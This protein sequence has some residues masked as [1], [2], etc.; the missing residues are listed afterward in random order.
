MRRRPSAGGAGAGFGAGGGAGFITGVGADLTTGVVANVGRCQTDMI[1]TLQFS[2]HDLE[3]VGIRE[4]IVG[5][6]RNPFRIVLPEP[7]PQT[8]IAAG[9]KAQVGTS[10]DEL[11]ITNERRKRG[12]GF[13]SGTVV[14]D[15]YRLERRQ[16][17][18]GLDLAADRIVAITDNDN[19]IND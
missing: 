8:D 5:G 12:L 18:E 4:R 3:R 10:H 14:D 19:D 17:P 13:R 15:E 2:E 16:V 7:P 1:A 9:A 11:G 6:D